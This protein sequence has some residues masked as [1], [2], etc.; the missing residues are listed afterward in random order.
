MFHN[1][2]NSRKLQEERE[3][4]FADF[5]QFSA[6]L[7]DFGRIFSHRFSH[8]I[9]SHQKLARSGTRKPLIKK[10]TSLPH[11]ESCYRRPVTSVFSVRT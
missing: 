3:L 11:L 6:I 1:P 5:T 4:P 8:G 10:S 9:Q 7:A 2:I